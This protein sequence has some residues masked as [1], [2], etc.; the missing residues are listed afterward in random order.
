MCVCVPCHYC[1][2]QMHTYTQVKV[3]HVSVQGKMGEYDVFKHKFWLA[4]HYMK[5]K[6]HL[7][8][9]LNE[10]TDIYIAENIFFLKWK[11]VIC[12]KLFSYPSLLCRSSNKVL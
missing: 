1:N 10:T 11:Y 8:D 5:K 9:N 6:D 7:P 3:E 12:K 2:R 4:I